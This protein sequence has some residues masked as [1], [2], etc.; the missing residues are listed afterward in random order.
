[1]LRDPATAR[2]QN[3]NTITFGRGQK[4]TIGAEVDIK[5]DV[6]PARARKSAMNRPARDGPKT[7]SDVFTHKSEPAI[8][9]AKMVSHSA[10]GGQ[11][12][13]ACNHVPQ[14]AR[15]IPGPR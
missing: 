14:P 3:V 10:V 2:F 6:A 1:M 15:S 7:H 12:A 13:L 11:N 4:L 9:A 8:V 5:Y